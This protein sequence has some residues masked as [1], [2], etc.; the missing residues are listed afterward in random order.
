MRTRSWTVTRSCQRSVPCSAASTVPGSQ[1]WEPLRWASSCCLASRACKDASDWCKRAWDALALR[2][3][4]ALTRS[5]AGTLHTGPAAQQIS[6][7]AMK[8]S[9]SRCGG[10][11]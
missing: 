9:L 1:A 6:H 10:D 7:R 5:H 4:P 2:L 3:G 8:V 11:C